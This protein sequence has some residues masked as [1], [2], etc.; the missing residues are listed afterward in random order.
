[1]ASQS[2]NGANKVNFQYDNDGLLSGA[3]PLT[4]TR[5]STNGLISGSTLGVATDT[6]T[7]NSFGEL[8]GDTA[9]VRGTPVYSFDFTRDADGRITGNTEING[10]INSYVY[11]YDGAGRL[12]SAT[13]N[14][15]TDTYT[16]DTNSNR[17]SVTTPLVTI[18]GTYD[19]QDRLLTNGTASYTYTANG[20]LTS[21]T[22]GSQRTIY[23]YDVLG[24]L[25]AVA[26][27]NGTRINYLIDP[28]NHR[29]GKKVNGVLRI[30]FLYDGD[31]IIAQ[32]NGSNQI[33]S[34]F[35]YATGA[36]SPNYMIS[37]GVTYRIF[38][39]QLGSPR[40]IVNASTGAIAEQISYDEFGKCYWRY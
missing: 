20:E 14:S 22:I 2:L 32:L 19:G 27:P 25:I 4:V 35:V 15:A 11:T 1:V 10:T 3:G 23:T 8:V 9:A 36:D 6:R 13:R 18:R 39:D 28:E 38:P 40:V 31:R 12:A 30:G 17:L 21:Q 37:G 26:L 7:Y 34:E 5:S 29:V 16:Y 33:I 24:N